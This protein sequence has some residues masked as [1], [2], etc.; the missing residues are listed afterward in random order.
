MKFAERKQLRLKGYD[1]SQNGAFYVTI[2]TYHRAKLF[3]DIQSVGANLCVRPNKSAEILVR[4]LH[5]LENKYIGVTVD[6]FCIMPDHIHIVLFREGEHIGSPLP[7]I[8]KWFK[9]QTTNDYIKGVK[10]GN[11]T[12][13]DKHIWQRNYYEHIIRGE[14]D[15]AEI[16]TYI[17]NNPIN[18]IENDL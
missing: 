18:F 14:N 16:R 13:F 4:W 15:L 3:G 5:E 12:P 2:C 7:E 6:C 11:F 10:K 17:K 9:T 8:V 1:Y